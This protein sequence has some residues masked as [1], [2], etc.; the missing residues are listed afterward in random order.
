MALLD[1]PVPS[2]GGGRA[3]VTT[4]TTAVVLASTNIP[5][6]WVIVQ[7]E[8]N[9]TGLI[10]VGDSAVVAAV[11][12]QSNGVI[13]SAGESVTLPVANLNTLYIDS[14]VSTDGVTYFYGKTP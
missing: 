1:N 7:A 14:T 5:I 9:N 3:F 13:L 6:A 2:I 12:T 4:A 10:A 8:T 11:G